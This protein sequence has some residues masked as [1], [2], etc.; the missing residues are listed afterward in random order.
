MG[1]LAALYA[2]ADAA[3]LGGTLVPVGGHSPL[4]AAAAGCPLVAG[5]H[6]G[7]QLD[8][9]EPLER[10]G[11][12]VRVADAGEAARAL[13]R[14]LADPDARRR[15]GDAARDEVARRRGHADRLA[16]WVLEMIR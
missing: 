6:V 8:L 11:A 3:L 7:H 14:L 12:L 2:L 15:A 10:A 4:E 5:P 9:V 13:A 1:V 16:G